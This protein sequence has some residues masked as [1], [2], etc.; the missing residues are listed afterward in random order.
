MI[1]VPSGAASLHGH[2]TLP[3]SSSFANETPANVG[4]ERGDLVHDLGRV[5]PRA[6]GEPIAVASSQ[7]T[8]HS[9]FPVAGC[10]HRADPVDPALGV[11]ER[12]VLLQEG[13]AGE[14]DVRVR[15]RSR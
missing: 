8:S 1:G 7:T 2:C 15:S 12:A 10:H 9:C 14:E 11:G 4:R 13:G 3:T 5:A 6:S